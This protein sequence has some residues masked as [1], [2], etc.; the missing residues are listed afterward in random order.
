MIVCTKSK[1]HAKTPRREG[2]K[3]FAAL[4]FQNLRPLRN[5]RMVFPV[6]FAGICVIRGL[7]IF[8]EWGGFAANMGWL[9]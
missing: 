3:S 7:Q 1:P 9:R 4:R 8:V 5:L 6:L 2:I